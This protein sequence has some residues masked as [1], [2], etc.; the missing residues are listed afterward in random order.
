M[1]SGKQR[2]PGTTASYIKSR[3]EI[4]DGK[5]EEEALGTMVPNKLGGQSMYS[6]ADLNYDVA[7]GWLVQESVTT[8]ASGTQERCF[9][10]CWPKLEERGW[11]IQKARTSV[12]PLASWFYLR[13][14]T[15]LKPQHEWK[16]GE[17]Y[18]VSEEEIMADE[19]LVD[20][21]S[22]ARTC[23]RK[24]SQVTAAASPPAAPPL[25]KK[26]KSRV[27]KEKVGTLY[28]TTIKDNELPAGI[29]K[30]HGVKTVDLLRWNAKQLPEIRPCSKLRKGTPVIVAKEEE[31]EQKKNEK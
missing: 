23:K 7:S 22:G 14:G 27:R 5:N 24:L 6:R 28:Y 10:T 29:A 9:T 15:L 31:E 25:E 16:H 2:C 20:S 13:P 12:H 1:L 19:K 18:L 17:H 26:R 8:M 3:C 4:V 11:T 30:Q 21:V